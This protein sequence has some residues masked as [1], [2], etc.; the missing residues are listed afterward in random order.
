ML[1][2]RQNNTIP[3]WVYLT[4]NSIFVAQSADAHPGGEHCY[5]WRNI[6]LVQGNTADYGDP[7]GT[8]SLWARSPRD[9]SKSCRVRVVMPVWVTQHMAQYGF[10]PAGTET[11]TGRSVHT[12]RI[13]EQSETEEDEEFSNR[14]DY[15][16]VNTSVLTTLY[17]LV[18]RGV[19]V[20]NTYSC[21]KAPN[22]WITLVVRTG[23]GPGITMNE[24]SLLRHWR[25]SRPGGESGNWKRRYRTFEVNENATIHVSMREWSAKKSTD[26]ILELN[27]KLA[28]SRF[29]KLKR[30]LADTDLVSSGAGSKSESRKQS[31]RSP[32]SRRLSSWF[33]PL[34]G[35]SPSRGS[36]GPMAGSY[37]A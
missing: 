2:G 5:R 18:Y 20:V 4:P 8:R 27:V 33:S 7:C 30:H 23:H 25:T 35:M 24:E 9:P 12:P 13:L 6:Y 36:T 22:I 16:F 3:R 17:V 21:H 37:T 19:D 34:L 15:I 28:G 14:L 26:P 32:I 11:G 10:V 31:L 29:E 1:P